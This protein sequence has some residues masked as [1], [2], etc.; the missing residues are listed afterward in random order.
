MT[1]FFVFQWLGS[2]LE[3]LKPCDIRQLVHYEDEQTQ[4]VNFRKI[5]PTPE[6]HR[7]LKYM[8]YPRYFNLL[9]DAWENK[10]STN[11]RQGI[12]LDFAIPLQGT[13]TVDA[14]LF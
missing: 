3:D 7:Y 10:Y 13:F 4:L 12:G 1:F 14:C 5:F 8:E 11:R 6:S 2:I 9:L